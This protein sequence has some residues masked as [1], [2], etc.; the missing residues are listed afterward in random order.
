M[1]FQVSLVMSLL[2]YFN[3]LLKDG[4]VY[5]KKVSSL[6]PKQL[7]IVNQR[8]WSNAGKISFDGFEEI[9]EEFLSDTKDVVASNTAI[10]CK[11]FHHFY[12]RRLNTCITIHH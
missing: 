11:G 8:K 2:K 12:S 10:N 1:S 4:D 6:T 5:P 7:E 3:K 9:K